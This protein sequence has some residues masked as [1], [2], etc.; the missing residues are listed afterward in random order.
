MTAPIILDRPDI[1]APCRV[2]VRDGLVE[3]QQGQIVFLPTTGGPF[4][5]EDAPELAAALAAVHQQMNS[6]PCD[7]PADAPI[8]LDP[9]DPKYST[10]AATGLGIFHVDGARVRLETCCDHC[11]EET[12]RAVDHKAARLLA[13]VVAGMSDR[14]KD[15]YL[16]AAARV[17]TIFPDATEEQ[18][19]SFLA[20]FEFQE[21]AS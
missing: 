3:A 6:G 5:V 19:E 21:R 10:R 16:A 7:A 13:A 8:V 14:A 4:V 9:P 11:P 20:R 18:I 12:S 17:T 1:T 2:A 15:A